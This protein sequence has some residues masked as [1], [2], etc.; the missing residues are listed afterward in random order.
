MEVKYICTEDDMVQFDCIDGEKVYCVGDK[1][2]EGVIID[3]I[4]IDK[5]TF[6]EIEDSELFK[7]IVS[8][9][10]NYVSNNQEVLD[11]ITATG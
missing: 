4:V 7:R 1:V 11:E 5:D 2:R 6:E 10:Y 8:A 9:R 3:T